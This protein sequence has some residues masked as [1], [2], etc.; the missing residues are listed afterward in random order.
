MLL[1]VPGELVV[2]VDF[3][4]ALGLL[5]GR[6]FLTTFCLA[7]AGV[8]GCCLALDGFEEEEEA[9]AA[10]ATFLLECLVAPFELVLTFGGGGGGDGVDMVCLAR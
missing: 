6:F 9:A 3:C 4:P 10:A 7:C 1:V 8:V 5:P 2:D